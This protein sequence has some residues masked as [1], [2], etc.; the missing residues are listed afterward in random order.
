MLLEGV[1]AVIA[2]ATIMIVDNSEIAGKAPGTIYGAGL[3][4][5][6]AFLIGD[7]HLRFATTFGAMAFS[8]FVFD[9]LDVSTRLGRYIVQELLGW[10]GRG[11]ALLATAVTVVPPAI[12]IAFAGEG[13]YRAFWTLFGTSNQL[14]AALTLLAISVWLRRSG[15]RAWYTIAPMLFVMAVTLW[16]LALQARVAFARIS[17]AGFSADTVLMNGIVALMLIAL[18]AFLIL[19]GGRVLVARRA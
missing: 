1:V 13:S 19:E 6:L 16:S 2:L 7:E 18:A 15:R 4:R 12:F 10:V 11:G 17:D 8:T 9:T 5:F 3:G 14:L